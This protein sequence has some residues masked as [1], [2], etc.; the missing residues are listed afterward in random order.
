MARAVIFPASE[1]ASFMTDAD[2]IGDGSFTTR[3]ARR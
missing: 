3:W 2:L 1:D